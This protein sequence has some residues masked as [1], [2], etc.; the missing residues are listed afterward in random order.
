MLDFT[1]IFW[2]PV[3]AATESTPQ[4]QQTGAGDKAW[5]KMKFEF[6]MNQLIATLYSG[7]S[8]LVSCPICLHAIFSRGQTRLVN[9]F[10]VH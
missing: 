9:W 2:F 8:K 7:D 5:C 10:V 3:S 6:R 1:L 4:A